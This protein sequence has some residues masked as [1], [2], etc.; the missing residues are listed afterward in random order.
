MRSRVLR[1]TCSCAGNPAPLLFCCGDTMRSVPRRCLAVAATG[2]RCPTV[3]RHPAARSAALALPRPSDDAASRTI[4]EVASL[5]AL[6]IGESAD[7]AAQ[8]ASTGLGELSRLEGGPAAAPG[9][10]AEF[11]PYVGNYATYEAALREANAPRGQLRRIVAVA[12]ASISGKSRLAY[13]DGTASRLVIF[14]RVWKHAQSFTPGWASY[15]ALA[16]HWRL[17]CGSLRNTIAATCRRPRWQ[18]CVSWQRASSASSLTC[19]ASC[20]R[21]RRGRG[22]AASGCAPLPAQPQGRRGRG[23]LLQTAAELRRV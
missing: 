21:W 1:S 9:L 16:R 7:L 17:P 10:A 12:Q 3:S 23:F 4:S 14:A 13:A 2:Q 20:P 8:R 19:R 18:R 15:M 11:L 6:G 5:V 22:A